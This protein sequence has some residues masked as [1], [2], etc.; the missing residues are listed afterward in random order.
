MGRLSGPLRQTASIYRLLR[1]RLFRFA[2]ELARPRGGPAART[3]RRIVLLASGFGLIATVLA[4]PGKAG[5]FTARMCKL[6]VLQPHLS[7]GCGSL[8]VKGIPIAEERQAWAA[9][10]PGNCE[11][12]GVYVGRFPKG[13]YRPEALARLSRSRTVR[14]NNETP[15]SRPIEGYVRQA[16]TIHATEDAAAA[17]A[18]ASARV[19]ADRT[20]SAFPARLL[21][22][23]L[24]SV[25]PSCAEVGGGFVCGADYAASCVVAEHI[26]TQRCD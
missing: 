9:L 5:D 10:E 3:R 6:P 21:D 8:G 1:R 23:R 12:L 11:A 26:V 16:R 7:D 22:V 18:R 4:M 2:S 17:E 25:R 19:D 13:V 15:L 24:T 14:A 20:C